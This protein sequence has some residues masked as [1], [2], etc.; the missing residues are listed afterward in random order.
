MVAYLIPASRANCAPLAPL[1]SNSSSNNSRRCAGTHTRPRPSCFKI[2]ALTL[3]DV[4]GTHPLTSMTPAATGA[5][6]DAYRRA[7]TAALPTPTHPPG[8]TAS[9]DHGDV[10]YPRP[11]GADAAPKSRLDALVF[12]EL[13]IRRLVSSEDRAGHRDRGR[14][15]PEWRQSLAGMSVR[16]QS[17]ALTLG[18]RG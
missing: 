2:S 12:R 10:K 17:A 3:V 8:P 5:Q 1:L 13:P 16:F 14:R 18:T 4:I 15:E 7:A 9:K 11:C 6:A